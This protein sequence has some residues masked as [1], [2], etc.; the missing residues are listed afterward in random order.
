VVTQQDVDAFQRDGVVAV[1]GLL[2][3]WI[4]PLRAAMP[5]LLETSYD[6]VKKA[7]YEMAVVVRANDGMWRTNETFRRFL[8]ESPVGEVAT[9]VMRSAEA[10]LYEDLLLYRQLGADGEVNWHRDAP[11]WPLTGT[12]L[13]SI[14]F[15]LEEVTAETGAMRFIAGSHRDGDEL[16]S[17]DP[18]SPNETTSLGDRPVTIVEAQPGDVTVFHPR[19]IHTVYGSAPD[20]PRRSFTIRLTGD[21]VRFHPKPKMYHAW[22]HDCGLKDGDPLDH[23]WFPVVGRRAATS[24]RR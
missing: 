14:W 17:R 11:R 16:V 21:D 7:G 4:E 3:D 13:S 24:A 2:V 23:P 18:R 20:R 5:E 10:R 8:F 9:T 15:S 22:M 12:Q 6:P 19:A 1:R